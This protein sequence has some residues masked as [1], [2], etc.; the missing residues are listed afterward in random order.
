M[1]ARC[2]SSPCRRW[3]ARWAANHPTAGTVS[4]PR[5]ATHRPADTATPVLRAAAGPRFSWVKTRSDRS[6]LRLRSHSAVP[7][8]EPSS[9]TT[10]SNGGAPSW[11]TRA[12]STSVS[13]GSRLCVGTTTDTSGPDMAQAYPSLPGFHDPAGVDEPELEAW[14]RGELER[15]LDG[16]DVRGALA[17]IDR[18]PAREIG[19]RDLVGLV[20]GDH[21]AAAAGIAVEQVD[22]SGDEGDRAGAVR[23]IGIGR[24]QHRQLARHHPAGELPQAGREPAG[25]EPL[26]Q[27]VA[28]RQR[29]GGVFG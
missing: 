2:R 6:K 4:S 19:L 1:T 5:K 16:A 9:T 25:H 23:R 27:A 28:A 20:V 14:R 24:Q 21:Q 22:G 10:T 15:R 13:A 8:V 7:S 12:D 26:E 11:R 18:G 17:G 29:P 3:A